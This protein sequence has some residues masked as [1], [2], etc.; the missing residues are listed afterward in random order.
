[1][2]NVAEPAAEREYPESWFW[3]KDGD[4]ITGRFVRFDRAPTKDY[5]MKAILVLDVDGILRSVWLT[6]TV[7]YNKVRD[8]VASRPNQNLE[9][10]E[11][12]SIKRLEKTEGEGSRQG[13]WKFQ[14][15]FPDRPEPTT[16]E[17]FDLDQGPVTYETEKAPAKLDQ[18]AAGSQDD[19][20]PW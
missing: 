11:R 7:L 15:L 13:Y 1:M 14:V 16:S 4:H 10:G 17:L 9:P 12:I 19:D 20:I 6:A 3:E 18:P 8:E 5:G 2:G